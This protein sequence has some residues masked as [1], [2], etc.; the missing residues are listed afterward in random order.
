MQ[1]LQAEATT[2]VETKVGGRL[3]LGRAK[4]TVEAGRLVVKARD[5]APLGQAGRRRRRLTSSIGDVRAS[6]FMF[7]RAGAASANNSNG[8]SRRSSMVRMAPRRPELTRKLGSLWL[9]QR[10][11]VWLRGTLGIAQR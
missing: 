8:T 10:V 4:A 2:E 5:P 9:Q 7:D 1:Q 3:A 6:L 11:T